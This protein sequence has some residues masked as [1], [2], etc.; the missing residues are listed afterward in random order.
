MWF[1]L[2]TS[3]E[4]HV[5]VAGA[6]RSGTTLIKA[7]LENHSAA[8]GPTRESTGLFSNMNF[9]QDQW[10]GQT[11]LD[12]RAVA[13][14]LKSSNNIIALYD[15]IAQEMRSRHEAAVFVDKVP[16]PPSRHRLLYVTSK[17][18]GAEWIHIVRDGRDCYCSA[19]DHPH[20][21]QSETVAKF[22][23][24]W[25]SCVESH[26]ASI[27]EEQKYTI[28]YEDLTRSPASVVESVM[29]FV[30]LDFEIHQVEESSRSGYD[31]GAR[32]AH[33][34]LQKPITDSSVGRW[35]DEMSTK[36]VKVFRRHAGD[37]LRRFGYDG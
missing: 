12:A 15:R 23:K 10:W 20:V 13:P 32:G 7:V 8:C 25:K 35:K 9:Y 29:N 6:P 21:P 2:G 27:P 4:H 14:L 16:W 17:F 11:G 5:F 24:Y 28:R 3:D 19:R 18:K 30:G 1:T 36:E 31:K 33:S 22:S 34:R 37:A 26:E